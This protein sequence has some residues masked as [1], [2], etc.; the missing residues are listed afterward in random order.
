MTILIE[1][2]EKTKMEKKFCLTCVKLP[3]DGAVSQ[4]DLLLSHRLTPKERTL[5][6]TAH[7]LIP[8]H[9]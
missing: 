1:L 2:S 8:Y 5:N 4:L 9:K 3:E 7:I 6:N